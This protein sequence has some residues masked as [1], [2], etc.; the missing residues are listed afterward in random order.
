MALS[1]VF[2]LG[3][4]VRPS[5]FVRA[6]EGTLVSLGAGLSAAYVFVH[7]LAELAEARVVIAELESVPRP[8]EGRIVYFVGLLGFLAAYAL[9]HIYHPGETGSANQRRSLV[10]HVAGFALYVALVAYL[11]VHGLDGAPHQLFGLAMAAH[12][13]VINR[14]LTDEYGEA[15]TWR[16]RAVL[17]TAVIAGWIV[18]LSAGV[19]RSAI[20]MLLAFVSGAVIMNS[21]VSELSTKRQGHLGP[22]IAGAVIF[23]VLLIALETW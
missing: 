22:F 15:Y 3:S 7:V 6:R 20:A 11:V 8:F 13:L 1:S 18:G 10:R 19:P 12:F 2:L 5:E 23:G 9:D 21:A 17:S 16:F 4:L 14:T